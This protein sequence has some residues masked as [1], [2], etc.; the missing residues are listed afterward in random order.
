M[1]YSIR[2]TLSLFQTTTQT[3]RYASQATTTEER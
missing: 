3:A 2:K 1:Q